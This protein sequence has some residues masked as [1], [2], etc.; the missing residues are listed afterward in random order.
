MSIFTP[1]LCVFALES[2]STSGD[3]FFGRMGVLAIFDVRTDLVLL[4]VPA[5]FDLF[6]REKVSLLFQHLGSSGLLP[7]FS[8]LSDDLFALEQVT[9]GQGFFLCL[10]RQ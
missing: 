6:Q 7:V 10:K 3:E 4:I 8:F 5:E 9:P 1:V 2:K